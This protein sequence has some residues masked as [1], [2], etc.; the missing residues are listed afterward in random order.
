MIS[1]IKETDFQKECIK[2][3]KNSFKNKLLVIN[4]H[5]GGYTNKGFPD[6]TIFGNNKAIV[7][8]LKGDSG[9]KLQDD[10][11]VWKNRFTKVKTPWYECHSIDE[12]KEIIHK[13][14]PNETK[15]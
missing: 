15:L 9:Y 11:I 3:I 6:L 10:Q 8:E 1:S 13:E 5:G 4:N 7:C 14:F 12:F 2:W